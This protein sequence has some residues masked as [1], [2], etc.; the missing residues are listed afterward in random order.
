[1]DLPIEAGT[2]LDTL[3]H[4]EA[5]ISVMSIDEI[6]ISRRFTPEMPD[7]QNK[8]L[9]LTRNFE[10]HQAIFASLNSRRLELSMLQACRTGN[11]RLMEGTTVLPNTVAPKGSFIAI[12]GTLLSGVLGVMIVLLRFG[13]HIAAE[14]TAENNRDYQKLPT[15]I[16]A[17]M[18]ER[19]NLLTPE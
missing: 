8:I 18:A 3:V 11:V 5:D 17:N 4:V 15:K 1:M 7:T 2:A 12:F 13:T 9:H 16:L 14:V 6:A 10:V 19:K